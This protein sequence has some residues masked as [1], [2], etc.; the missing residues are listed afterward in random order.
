VDVVI[1]AG[2]E[3]RAED[4]LYAVTGV[5][6]KA[7]LPI[8]GKPMIRYVVEALT[9]SPE[10]ERFVVVGLTP[11]E[12]SG[13]GVPVICTPS[14]DGLFDNVV[15][16]FEKLH[17]VNPGTRLTILSSADIP[18][19]TTE[20]VNWLVKTCGETD[21]D[22]YYTVVERA[23]MERRFPQA[24]RTFVPLRGGAYCGGDIFMAR[25]DL[26]HSNQALFDR[27]MDARK[28]FRQQ[29]R[30]IGPGFLI[31]FALRRLTVADA[32]CHIS[33]T[34]NVR[35]RAIVTPFA[36]M[37]MDV[38]KPHQLEIVRAELEGKR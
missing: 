31:R 30:L 35:G 4:P 12:C 25:T 18:L 9:G 28:N 29:V 21:H 8:A 10:V 23:V 2:G 37:G 3:V 15:A 33:K 22:I 26:I 38:D 6:R 32:E 34:L 5:A 16:G 13:L 17:E 1:L 36:E 19:L 11:D 7:L 24:G 14:R 27:L 20:M